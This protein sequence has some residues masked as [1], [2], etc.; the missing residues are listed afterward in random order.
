MALHVMHAKARHAQ[1]RRD[2]APERGTYHQ[3]PDK[4]RTC[5]V[6]H[7]VD[8]APLNTP[9]GEHLINQR[10]G[11]SHVVTT[12]KLWHHTAI[13]RMDFDLRIKRIRQ[14]ASLGVIQRHPGLITAG[15]DTQHP[16]SR[17]PFTS[18]SIIRSIATLPM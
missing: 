13:L 8:V 15:F 16:H 4:P 10:Q 2:R 12:G 11:F 18:R 3:R 14:Q 6:R 17:Y 9:L 7:A 5:R 1:A